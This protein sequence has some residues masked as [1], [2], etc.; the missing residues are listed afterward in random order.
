[1]YCFFTYTCNLYLSTHVECKMNQCSYRKINY[2]S[3]SPDTAL[4]RLYCP[5]LKMFFIVTNW[6]SF[7]CEA[8]LGIIT[9]YFGALLSSSNNIQTTTS[10]VKGLFRSQ[11]IVVCEKCC[12]NRIFVKN[13]SSKLVSHKSMSGVSLD[14]PE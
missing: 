7:L 10:F 2:G 9:L 12:M 6:A 1:M 4:T 3:F 13:C 5:W 14:Y 8:F 11:Q